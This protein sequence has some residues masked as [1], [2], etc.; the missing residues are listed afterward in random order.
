VSEDVRS[1][2]AVDRKQH[3]AALH[4]RWAA[5]PSV[6]V[7]AVGEVTDAPVLDIRRIV[8]GEQNE[9]YDVTLEGAASLIVRIAL[10]APDAHDREVWVIGQCASRGLPA[11]RVHTH[12]HVEV[13]SGR[14][15]VIVMEKL[16]GE[17][18]CDLDPDELDVRRVLGE[19]GAWL[20]QLHTIPVQ[21]FGYLDGSGVGKLATMDGW[22]AG[23]TTEARAFEE[24]GRSVGLE[25]A[26][27]RSWLLEIVDSLRETP[28][29][30]TLIHNDLWADHVLVHDGHLSGIIDFGE[31]A[32]EPAANDFAKWDFAEG[33]RYPVEWIRAG[34]GDRSLF[35]AAQDRTYRALWFANGL[36]RL[37]WYHETGFRR[38]VEAARDRLLSDP[39]R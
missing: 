2:A 21:G 16:P 32:A 13:G 10:G 29:R 36:W 4:E 11:P 24:A 9:V 27:I 7:S 35:E 25:A 5:P 18:L 17:R 31:V 3:L 19:V 23:L 20:T 37:R 39:E 12:C 6:V 33:E 22:L 38:G 15:S 8:A 26:A 14:R 28:P 1:P 34:Y 30:I